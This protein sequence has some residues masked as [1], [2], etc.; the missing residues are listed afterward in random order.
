[1]TTPEFKTMGVVSCGAMGRGIAQ[2]AAQAGARVRLFDAA[3]G[4]A[5]RARDTLGAL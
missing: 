3:P 2:L 4:A 5:E 1:M